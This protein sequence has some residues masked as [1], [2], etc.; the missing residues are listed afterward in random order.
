MAAV[1]TSGWRVEGHLVG[2]GL[3]AADPVAVS[4]YRNSRRFR[5][6]GSSSTHCG[7]RDAHDRIERKGIHPASVGLRVRGAGDHG[8]AHHREQ[9]R[10]LRHNSRDAVYDV[11]GAAARLYAA[12]RRLYSEHYVSAWISG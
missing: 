9:A 3:P 5:L 11:F 7:P 10:P 12:D 4:I 1:A 6:P 2:A 8:D